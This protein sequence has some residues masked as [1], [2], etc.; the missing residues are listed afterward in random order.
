LLL[1]AP[2]ASRAAGRGWRDSILQSVRWP[3]GELGSVVVGA[4][5][6]G[7]RVVAWE[8]SGWL[9]PERTRLGLVVYAAARATTARRFSR[10]RALMSAPSFVG[11]LAVLR[12][13]R[14]SV[15]IVVDGT[16]VIVGDPRRGRWA[17]PVKVGGVAVVA[18][19]G[20]DGLIDVATTDTEA[21]GLRIATLVPGRGWRVTVVPLAVPVVEQEITGPA[22]TL[23]FAGGV[24]YRRVPH[25]VRW[26][27]L[28][29]PVQPTRPTDGSLEGP[30]FWDGHA[31]VLVTD[32]IAV[33]PQGASTW[34]VSPPLPHASAIVGRLFDGRYVA[35]AFALGGVVSAEWE[36]G[37]PAWTRPRRVA[38]LPGATRSV[39]GGR[40]RVLMGGRLA[41]V[42]L[43][44]IGD[45]G[46]CRVEE[47]V[48]APLG[49]WSPVRL[50]ASGAFAGTMTVVD[51]PGALVAM[52]ATDPRLDRYSVGWL[53]VGVLSPAGRWKVRTRR[54]GAAA[55]IGFPPAAVQVGAGG[56][57]A[58]AVLG[59]YASRDAVFVTESP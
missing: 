26:Q 32:R 34:I 52:W 48:R 29:L 12:T 23:L 11:P 36:I 8:R 57:V 46:S 53:G 24:G 2:A 30:S 51:R 1:T 58:V 16:S 22:T 13:G 54:H 7:T 50:V 31:L 59:R 21:S 9:D 33:L 15:A 44:C 28:Q 10:P 45:G 38:A 14:H 19:R 27:R 49:T 47:L 39:V 6:D 55:V 42:W 17:R 25:Q 3:V 18:L 43:R 37:A 4:S 35:T 20:D 41:F 56:R 5:A 40:A